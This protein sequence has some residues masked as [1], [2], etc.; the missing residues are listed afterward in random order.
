MNSLNKIDTLESRF[1]LSLIIYLIFQGSVTIF[2]LY[3]AFI[4]ILIPT[5]SIILYLFH[6]DGIKIITKKGVIISTIIGVYFSKK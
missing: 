2:G 1:V 6:R 3:N 4:N 5:I